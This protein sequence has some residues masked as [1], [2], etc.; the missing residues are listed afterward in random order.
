MTID[1]PHFEVSTNVICTISMLNLIQ[2]K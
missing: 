2:L 1:S